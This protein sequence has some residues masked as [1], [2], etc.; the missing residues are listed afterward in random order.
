MVTATAHLPPLTITLTHLEGHTCLFKPGHPTSATTTAPAMATVIIMVI[1][2]IL[3]VGIAPTATP[4]TTIA[5]DVIESRR[6][7]AT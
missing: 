5:I 2:A 3:T 7:P 1:V 6:F 4:N